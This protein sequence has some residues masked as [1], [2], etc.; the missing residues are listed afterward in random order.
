MQ[1]VSLVV[2]QAGAQEVRLVCCRGLLVSE[3]QSLNGV[4]TAYLL[5]D[6]CI[7]LCMFTTEE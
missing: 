5:P 2:G 7:R 4:L 1:A 3:S 6:F